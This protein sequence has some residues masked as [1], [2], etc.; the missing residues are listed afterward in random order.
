[1]KLVYFVCIAKPASS[2]AA[3]AKPTQRRSQAR[4][5]TPNAPR[6]NAS[7][8]TS[9]I[10]LRLARN[11]AEKNVRQTSGI[12]SPEANRRNNQYSEHTN[13][14]QKGNSQTFHTTGWSPKSRRA[15]ARQ[16]GTTGGANTDVAF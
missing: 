4:K 8:G 9:S 11:A 6:L 16:Y 13:S 1:M 7:A 14:R 15:R 3:I 10:K 12:S 5:K 2:P